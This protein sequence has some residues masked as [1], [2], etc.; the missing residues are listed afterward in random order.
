MY[1]P[2]LT[3][4]LE[5]NIDTPSRITW[6]FCLRPARAFMRTPLPLLANNCEFLC[7]IGARDTFVRPHFVAI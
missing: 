2:P 3:Q 6:Q 4:F 1:P 5:K 7:T